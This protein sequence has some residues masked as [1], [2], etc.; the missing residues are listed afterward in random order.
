VAKV[1]D[2]GFSV[3]KGRAPLVDT[4]HDI[5]QLGIVMGRLA[6]VMILHEKDELL[7][8]QES[9]KLFEELAEQCRVSSRAN[10]THLTMDEVEETL[11]SLYYRVWFDTWTS[12][13]IRQ[14]IGS[15]IP[16]SMICS[17]MEQYEIKQAN[18]KQNLEQSNTPMHDSKGSDS[19]LMDSH[20]RSLSSSNTNSNNSNS[21]NNTRQPPRRDFDFVEL[22]LNSQYDVANHINDLENPKDG[23]T[24]LMWAVEHRC[25]EAARALIFRL[26]ADVNRPNCAGTYPLHRAAGNDK[27]HRSLAV[28]RVEGDG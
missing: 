26:R 15:F 22:I 20:G 25:L 13:N 27:F 6:E 3:L 11:Q 7:Q 10:R 4:S 19:P 18:L 21:S 16:F 17:L 23:G 14:D 28:K 9:R 12:R 1:A 8:S 24:L 5:N 2:F